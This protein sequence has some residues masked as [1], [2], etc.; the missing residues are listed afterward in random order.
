MTE[1]AELE[2][3]KER[4]GIP[5][6]DTGDDELIQRRI[7][8]ASWAIEE[9]ANR[10]HK[11]GF[12]LDVTATARQYRP[13]G[14]RVWVRE[15]GGELLLIDDVGSADGLV[16]ELGDGTDWSDVT[17]EVEVEPLSAIAEGKPVTA[18]LL[19]GGRWHARRVRVTARWGW[20]A[21]PAGAVEATE[22]LTVRLHRRK[23]APWGVAGF[24]ES[25]TVQIAKQDPDV[26]ALVEGLRRTGR[27]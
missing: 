24:G 23:D 1:Y 6:D 27:F 5:E 19:E 8:S 26:M 12:G 17:T 18:L 21:I 22:I 13:G 7:V 3:V 15:L 10:G 20:P 11:P 4:L 9:L 2:N 25:G 14:R 16:V